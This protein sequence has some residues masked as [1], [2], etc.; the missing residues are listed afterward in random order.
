MDNGE[1]MR[2]RE[3]GGLGPLRGL[4]MVRA[5]SP[6]PLQSEPCG[7]SQGIPRL[8]L[9]GQVCSMPSSLLVTQTP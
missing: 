5:S 4:A 1:W 9:A 6:V 8:T 2:G 7:S 3:A